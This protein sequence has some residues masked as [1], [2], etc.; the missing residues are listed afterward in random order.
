MLPIIGT[1]HKPSSLKPLEQ[2]YDDIPATHTRK[3]QHAGTW[4]L[5]MAT[6]WY[7]SWAMAVGLTSLG[8]ILKPFLEVSIQGQEMIPGI[9]SK[10]RH[11]K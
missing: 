1:L 9:S 2:S 5:S 3:Q 11:T 7:C 8:G 6:V 10:S 4:M